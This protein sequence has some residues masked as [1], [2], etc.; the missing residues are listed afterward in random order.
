MEGEASELF[1]VS[2][3]IFAMC[4]FWLFRGGFFE[5]FLCC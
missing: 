5:V 1:I 2:R 3:K 4:I